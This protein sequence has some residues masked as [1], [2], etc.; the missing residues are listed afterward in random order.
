MSTHKQCYRADVNT[1][2]KSACIREK[3]RLHAT[4]FLHHEASH[5]TV[6]DPKNY[7]RMYAYHLS[8]ECCGILRHGM[9]YIICRLKPDDKIIKHH[10][11]FDMSTPTRI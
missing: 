6:S 11:I 7:G 2:K 4:V 8:A 9:K 10:Q 1:R 3:L 5:A